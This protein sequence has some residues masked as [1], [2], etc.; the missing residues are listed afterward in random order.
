MIVFSKKVKLILLFSGVVLLLGLAGFFVYIIL[1][2]QEHVKYFRC[3]KEA[4]ESGNYAEATKCLI[5]C[6]Q[7][8]SANEAAWVLIAK[9]NE[10]EDEWEKAARH[11]DIAVLLNSL[12]KEYFDHEIKALY[13]SH[14]FKKIYDLL[15]TKSLEVQQKYPSPFILALVKNENDNDVVEK[16]ISKFSAN[17]E[18][19]ELV[20]LY[21]K[22]RRKKIELPAY[23]KR[24]ELPADLK[25]IELLAHL[26]DVDLLAHL[27]ALELEAHLNDLEKLIQLSKSQD[28]VLAIE[29]L[30]FHFVLSSRKNDLKTAE[31]LLKQAR[32]MDEKYCSRFLGDFYYQNKRYTDAANTY[33][34]VFPDHIS[35]SSAI[36]YAESLFFTENITDLKI[37]EKYYQKGQRKDLYDGGYIRAMIAYLNKDG[38][39]LV[40]NMKVIGGNIDTPIYTLLEFAGGI[41]SRN[42]EWIMNAVSRI[43]KEPGYKKKELDIYKKLQPLLLSYYNSGKSKDV[44]PIAALFQT[45]D[46]PQRIVWR[47]ILLDEFE[48][49]N[50]LPELLDY[51]VKSFPG[52]PVFSRIAISVSQLKKDYK[53]AVTYA[54]VLIQ[55]GDHSVQLYLEKAFALEALG[56]NPEAK[57]IYL[58]LL[59]KNPENI[60]IAKRGLLFAMQAGDK[61]IFTVVAKNPTLKAISDLEFLR[62]D[63]KIDEYKKMLSQNLYENKM[64]AKMVEDRELLFVLALNL[65]KLD[66]HERAIAIYENLK[67]YVDDPTLI[68]LNLSELYADIKKLDDALENA[69]RAWQRNTSSKVIK[70][71]YGLRLADSQ[72]WGDAIRMLDINAKDPRVKTA[73]IRSYENLV[74][75]TFEQH[76]YYECKN[77]INA[78]LLLSLESP[79]I[80]S[81]S[82]KLKIAEEEKPK[83]ITEKE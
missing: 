17:S 36:F 43:K 66:L 52:D 56:K 48:Q 62:T 58:Q 35:R 4:Y 28:R 25:G 47:I 40:T 64:D 81:Y 46:P 61:E 18:T 49:K 5:Q 15:I 71:C 31:D 23:S 75:N 32:E 76:R 45:M 33:K 38:Q 13:C 39:A 24:I 27:K 55:N 34:K 60:Q 44:A 30:L 70:D 29:A 3:G 11:W 41:E 79:I 21:M 53:K 10:Q 6:V 16:L 77:Y 22:Y 73:I 54:D 2:N 57:K 65:A 83:K 1:G 7:E 82:D 9:M 19:L 69:H 20:S 51:A 78:F 50:I 72:K 14:N 37:I 80:H 59:E 68:E 63:N 8:D 42:F 67:P 12:N 74:K 26:K